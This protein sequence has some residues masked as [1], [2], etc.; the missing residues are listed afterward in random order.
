MFSD[1]KL[2]FERKN[3]NLLLAVDLLFFLQK[4]GIVRVQLQQLI[5]LFEVG[6]RAPDL[7][8]NLSKCF[9][10]RRG[11]AA[12]LH[13]DSFNLVCHFMIL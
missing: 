3:V 4:V 1:L 9:T 5:Y 12:D 11:I 7:F 8:I 2:K 6:L 10:Q 13:S